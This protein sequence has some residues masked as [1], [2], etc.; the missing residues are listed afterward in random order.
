VSFKEGN[1]EVS[2]ALDDSCGRLQDLSRSDIRLHRLNPQG[3]FQ[4]DV[5]ASVFGV[6]KDAPVDGSMANFKIAMKWLELSEWNP[7]GI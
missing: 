4:E 7:Q 5:T 2:V 1:K 6:G 3:E